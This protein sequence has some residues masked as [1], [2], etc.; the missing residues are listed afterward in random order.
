[1]GLV[2]TMVSMV[3]ECI[4]YI[5]MNAFSK[6][7]YEFFKRLPPH[8]RSGSSSGCRRPNGFSALVGAVRRFERRQTRNF[9]G[10][11]CVRPRKLSEEYELLSRAFIKQIVFQLTSGESIR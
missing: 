11:V 6:D 2:H 10:G 5:T 1:M 8:P 3:I 7:I 9:G 4:K